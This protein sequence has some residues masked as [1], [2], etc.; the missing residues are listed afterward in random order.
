MGDDHKP[1]ALK[2]L[3]ARLRAARAEQHAH[4]RGPDGTR[5]ENAQ[6]QGW[7]WRIAIEMVVA[8]A[9]GGGIG[10]LLDTWLG[11]LPLFLILFF[12]LGA[13]AGI[14]NVYRAAQAINRAAWDEETGKDA[15]KASRDGTDGTRDGRT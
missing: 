5:A 13:G 8:V 4:E 3:D 10:W 7:A 2:K 11:T 12:L 9:F 15:D 14:R 6:A 1:D